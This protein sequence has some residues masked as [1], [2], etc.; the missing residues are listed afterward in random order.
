MSRS[1]ELG[2]RLALTFVVGMSGWGCAADAG[3]P[4]GT[5]VPGRGIDGVQLGGTSE[6]VGAAWGKPDIQVGTIWDY[7]SRCAVVT[8]DAASKVH[9]IG[10]GNSADPEKALASCRGMEVENGPRIGDSIA[11]VREIYRDRAEIVERS[12]KIGGHDIYVKSIGLHLEF[13]SDE[14]LNFAAIQANL[15]ATTPAPEPGGAPDR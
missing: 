15:P 8:F 13:R 1:R 6:E 9:M 10:I 7:S 3:G 11:R 14:A 4:S 2:M 5:L 12:F